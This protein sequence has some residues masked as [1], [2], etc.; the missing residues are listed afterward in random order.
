[1]GQPTPPP[2]G[3]G[4]AYH[5]SKTYVAPWERENIAQV[6]Y[7]DSSAPSLSSAER[8]GLPAL[9]ATRSNTIS[10][11]RPRIEA[12][13]KGTSNSSYSTSTFAEGTGQVT[14]PRTAPP[15]RMPYETPVFIPRAP[16]SEPHPPSF[17]KAPPTPPDSETWSDTTA[18]TSASPQSRQTI[19]P[20]PR[21][22]ASR[23]MSAEKRTQTRDRSCHS[24]KD[25][26]KM[27]RLRLAFKE[28]FTHHSVDE[29]H[30][31]R[32]ESRHWTDE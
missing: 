18:S 6:P 14:T 19:D 23:T 12:H 11:K 32:I 25:P 29:S 31:E 22:L 7:V 10:S 5:D 27:K 17:V 21:T 26:T 20:V 24:R 8:D 28:L 2:S 16:L 4:S 30:Y 13:T 15:S 9:W 1:M 3:V